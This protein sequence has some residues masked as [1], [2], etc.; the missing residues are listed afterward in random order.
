M[1]K[2]GKKGKKE[3]N[4]VELREKRWKK[5]EEENKGKKREADEKKGEKEGNRVEKKEKER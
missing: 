2:E 4:R 1:E 5:G 3:G